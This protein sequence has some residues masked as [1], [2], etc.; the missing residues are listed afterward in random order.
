MSD[1]AE[2]SRRV[3]DAVEVARRALDAVEAAILAGGATVPIPVQMPVPA[4]PAPARWA[5]LQQAAGYIGRHVDSTARLVRQHGL[6]RH[7]GGRWSVDL[8]RLDA[9]REGRAFDPLPASDYA[10][11][12]G[13]SSDAPSAATA[14]YSGHEAKFSHEHSSRPS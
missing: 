14:D 12:R 5:T 8:N 1:A 11:E 9:W 2:H 4:D 10:G 13:V 3:L 7:V 6:G